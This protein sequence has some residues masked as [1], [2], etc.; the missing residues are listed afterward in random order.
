MLSNEQI[1]EIGMYTIKNRSTVRN[2]AK[3]FNISKSTVHNV[4]RHKLL[5]ISPSLY[6]QV[7]KVLVTNMNSRHV[8]GGYATKMKYETNPSNEIVV[9][10]NYT[11]KKAIV[12][13]VAYCNCKDKYKYAISG[14]TCYISDFIK[15]KRDCDESWDYNDF[16]V[17]DLNNIPRKID[18]IV[19]VAYISNNYSFNSISE[20]NTIIA[21]N[22][23]HEIIRHT[24][25]YE[26][27][28]DINDIVIGEIYKSENVWKFKVLDK[29]ETFSLIDFLDKYR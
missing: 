28:P 20:L 16:I 6:S 27:N 5:Y 24:S 4:L 1:K 22:N 7:T 15:H 18:H 26:N 3:H 14:D 9:G 23:G 25:E 13:L 19:L 17:V 8:R 10:L 12:K 21:D 2:T 29:A 11:S